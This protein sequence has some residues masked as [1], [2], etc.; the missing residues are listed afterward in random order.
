MAKEPRNNFVEIKEALLY[1]VDGRSIT[2]T[3][4]VNAFFYY[5]DILSPFITGNLQITDS[6]VNLIGTLPIQGGERVTLKVVDFQD[7]EYEYDMYVWKVF[8][9]QFTKSIQTYNLGLVSKEAIYNEGVRLSEP[10]SGFPDEIVKKILDE[11]LNTSKDILT[12]SCKYQV[13]FFPEG[14]K[15]HSIIQSLMY[16]AVPKFSAGASSESTKAET[17]SSAPKTS[18]PKDTKKLSG[19]AGY[20]FFENRSGFN[21]KSID[22]YFSDGSDS[23]GGEAPVETYTS[24]PVKDP[25]QQENR[26]II[27]SYKF[28][29]EIDLFEQM[30]NGSYSTYA[31]FYNFS[32]GR[33][34]E[35][36]YNLADSFSNMAHLGSQET[37]GKV[38]VELSTRPTRIVTAIL[39][40]ETWYNGEDPASPEIEDG[41]GKAQFPDNHKYYMIQ[42][43]ARRYLMENQKLEIE[44]PGNLKLKAG[45]KIKVMLPNMSANELRKD[46]PYDEENSGTYL[47]SK[48]SHVTMFINSSCKTVIELIRDTYGMKEYTSN[49]T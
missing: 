23:F 11:Y 36:I 19:T 49:V 31:C 38:Q 33:Y 4:A 35:Y 22:Y 13:N 28:T 8:N 46:Q 25:A 6:G 45:D 7:E 40:H 48:I 41:S 32:T 12:D 24:K 9:R 27:E 10:L 37:L 17:T 26:F 39:D 43:F 29:N 5:E 2:I 14:R 18:V 3:N 20:L 34:E 21:F 16:K 42:G 1:S 47:I 15:A 30:R 44:V